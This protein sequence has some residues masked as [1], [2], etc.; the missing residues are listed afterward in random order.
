M[1]SKI[2]NIFDKYKTY[3]KWNSRNEE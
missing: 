2:Q 3:L 1:E